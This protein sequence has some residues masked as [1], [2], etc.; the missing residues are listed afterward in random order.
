MERDTK[1]EFTEEGFEKLVEECTFLP[2][3]NRRAMLMM[4]GSTI[5]T[6]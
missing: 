2:E 3:E 5:A 6:M 4:L 1:I